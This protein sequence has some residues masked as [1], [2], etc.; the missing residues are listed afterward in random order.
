MGSYVN[1]LLGKVGIYLPDYMASY[2]RR[3]E[4]HKSRILAHSLTSFYYV[5]HLWQ[6]STGHHNI[7]HYSLKYLQKTFL[8]PINTQQVTARNS[9]GHSC[10]MSVTVV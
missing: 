8:M 5:K 9:C 2:F 4:I 10:K 6:S 7:F 1:K 3:N